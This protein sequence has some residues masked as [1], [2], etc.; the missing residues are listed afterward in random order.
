M[1]NLVYLMTKGD[2]L[3]IQLL[4]HS[5]KIPCLPH[6]NNTECSPSQNLNRRSGLQKERPS[7]KYD[8]GSNDV[9]SRKIKKR[10]YANTNFPKQSE[11]PKTPGVTNG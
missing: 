11:N 8:I 10:F 1:M 7:S 9:D 3:T 5:K 2:P 4:S 6:P